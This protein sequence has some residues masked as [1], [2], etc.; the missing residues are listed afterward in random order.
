MWK[1]K[2]KTKPSQSREDREFERQAR[3]SARMIQDAIRRYGIYLP[4]SHR[5]EYVPFNRE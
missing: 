1:R 3:A 2:P 5:G 4:P